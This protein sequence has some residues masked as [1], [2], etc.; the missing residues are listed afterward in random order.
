[1]LPSIH[2]RSTMSVLTSRQAEE[3]YVN[4]H[5]PI[6]LTVHGLFTYERR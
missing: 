6:N 2:E 5:Q 1:M 3:L 4:A